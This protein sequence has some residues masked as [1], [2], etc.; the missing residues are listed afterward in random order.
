[1]AIEDETSYKRK[2]QAITASLKGKEHNWN[3]L[4]LGVNA[5]AE[6]MADKYKSNKSDVLN[7]QS[8]GGLALRMALG[9]TQVVAETK[10]FLVNHGVKLD[11]FGQ[12]VEL[13]LF[14]SSI[15]VNIPLLPALCLLLS[16][17]NASSAFKRRLSNHQNLTH[18][19]VLCSF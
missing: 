15:N 12:V 11:A 18:S 7:V 1:M 2:K 13:L 17:F 19:Q 4:F 9:E 14:P 6:I 3:T 16:D 10:E 5:V 8:K